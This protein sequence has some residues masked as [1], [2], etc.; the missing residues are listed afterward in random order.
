MEI[1]LNN[2]GVQ[3][4]VHISI[5]LVLQVPLDSSQKYQSGGCRIQL[6]ARASE[7]KLFGT[8]LYANPFANAS[9]KCVPSSRQVLEKLCFS[10][11]RE[12]KHEV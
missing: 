7:D 9:S 6:R 10:C 5:D 4:S 3:T 8:A 12:L 1:E 11:T 2:E